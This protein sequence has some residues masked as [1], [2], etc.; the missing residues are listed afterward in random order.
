MPT[1]QTRTRVTTKQ[2]R[3]MLSDAMVERIVVRSHA[4]DRV[5]LGLELRLDAD[6][7][8]MLEVR[9]L[10]PPRPREVRRT[11]DRDALTFTAVGLD[12]VERSTTASCFT[13]TSE[14][15]T[16]MV[17][18]GSSAAKAFAGSAGYVVFPTVAKGG[19][20]IGG[21][22]GKG[23]VYQHGNLIGRSTLT[24]LTIGLQA[25][26]QAYSEVIF[27]KDDAALENFTEPKAVW[28]NL[29]T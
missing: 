24:Q 2:V 10:A 13:S 26:G 19:L 22:R 27:L 21:A 15:S 18:A 29:N 16:S 14:S 7:R 25:G 5:E 17:K 4:R 11:V 12:G 8:P 1:L 28:M 20:G 23:Y 3:R 6:F 9:G